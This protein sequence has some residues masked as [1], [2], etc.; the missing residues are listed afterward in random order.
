MTT[1]NRA[2]GGTM[3]TNGT[4]KSAVKAAAKGTAKAGAKKAAAK[5]GAKNG[6]TKAKAREASSVEAKLKVKTNVVIDAT[7][8]AIEEPPPSIA[9]P[10]IRHLSW[11]YAL[12]KEIGDDAMNDFVVEAGTKVAIEGALDRLAYV[13]VVQVSED[14]KVTVLYPPKGGSR[15]MRPGARMRIPGGTGWIVTTTKGTLRTIASTY[16]LTDEQINALG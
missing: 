8:E 1:T 13:Y 5:A 10:P 9:L 15:R 3:K 4:K 2:K 11:G 14:R 16:P 12:L 7:E 6:T